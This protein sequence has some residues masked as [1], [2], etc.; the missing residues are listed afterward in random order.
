MQTEEQSDRDHDTGSHNRL[1][2]SS[3]ISYGFNGFY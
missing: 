2:E 3:F 1:D